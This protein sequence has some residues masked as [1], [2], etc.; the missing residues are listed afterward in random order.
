MGELGFKYR[1]NSDLGRR[2]T[3]RI[4]ADRYAS[5]DSNMMVYEAFYG[6]DMADAVIQNMLA[7]YAGVILWSLDDAMYHNNSVWTL[8]RWGFW[9]I[10]GAEAFGKA[11]D[12]Y[13]RPWF[14]TMSLLSRYFPKGMEINQVNLPNK[15]G[16]RAVAGIKGDKHTIAL[17]NSNS[18]DCYVSLTM[19][20]GMEL[21][22]MK[23]YSYVAS[24][25]GA[26]FT[27]AHDA[28]GFAAPENENV[29]L[30][31]RNSVKIEIPARSF[32]LYTNYVVSK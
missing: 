23:K 17:V 3:E 16:V 24:V 19:E 13:I 27:G 12:E 26:V 4:N 14:Y 31:L 28:L 6:V 15:K 21:K 2:N 25:E 7:G 1:T 5:D 29:T 18:E 11:T 9:N 10:L 32:I 8:K 30:D 22:G 20:H